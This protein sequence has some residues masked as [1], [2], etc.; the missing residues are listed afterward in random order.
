M[1]VC[2]D[3]PEGPGN[4]AL[5][6]KCVQSLLMI[7]EG[8][9]VKSV[10]LTDI[11]DED[12]EM[13]RHLI[14]EVTGPLPARVGDYLELAK[15]KLPT[16]PEALR[17]LVREQSLELHR[18]NRKLITAT[19]GIPKYRGRMTESGRMKAKRNP[20]MDSRDRKKPTTQRLKPNP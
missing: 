16:D 18:V 10:A 17:R 7:R 8:K 11:A 3:G 9:I 19:Q 5:N 15:L 20:A 4:L 12:R 2:L 1:V 14:E 6:R 13:V